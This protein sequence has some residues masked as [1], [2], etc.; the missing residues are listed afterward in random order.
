MGWG[1]IKRRWAR[2]QW[3]LSW[4]GH[5][6]DVNFYLVPIEDGEDPD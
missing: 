2:S 4:V 3:C 1:R 6:E 5:F